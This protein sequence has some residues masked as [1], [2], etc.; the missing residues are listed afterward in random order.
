MCYLDKE[1]NVIIHESE[2]LD[3][4]EL[5]NT[6]CFHCSDM[7]TLLALINDN[8]DWVDEATCTSCRLL[9]SVNLWNV[10]L[11][12]EHICIMNKHHNFLITTRKQAI[13]FINHEKCTPELKKLCEKILINYL[14]QSMN[15]KRT[16]E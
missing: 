3:N 14:P 1:R 7:A 4:E 10:L 11:I 13:N 12:P 2:Y 6:K 16:R 15:K 8:I 5:I 9:L